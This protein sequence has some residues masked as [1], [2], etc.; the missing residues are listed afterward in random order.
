MDTRN[1]LLGN[2]S[3]SLINANWRAL[4]NKLQLCGRNVVIVK[5][6]PFLRLV[7]AGSVYIGQN[8]ALA[9]G[10][11]NCATA[12][13]IAKL[14]FVDFGDT[15]LFTKDYQLACIFGDA[16][17]SSANDVVYKYT[18]MQDE[19][20]TISLSGSAFDTE[21]Y[22]FESMCPDEALPIACSDDDV[23]GQDGRTLNAHITG[24]ELS[25]GITYY[26]VIDGY[27]DAQ[28]RYIISMES[29]DC[30][31]CTDG[32]TQEGESNCGLGEN[33][34]PHDFVNGGCNSQ[35]PVFMSMTDGETICGSTA[36]NP[37]T[38]ARDTDWYQLVL[39]ER[40]IVTWLVNAEFRTQF[41]IV[42]NS[43]VADCEAVSC[44]LKFT[45]SAACQASHVSAMLDQG[46]W[47]FFVAPF[48]QDEG[49]CESDYTATI[50]TI[51]P[52]DLNGDGTVNTSD[53]LILLGS[54]GPCPDQPN[55]CAPDLDGD[56]EVDVNDLAILLNSWD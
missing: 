42:D 53:L 19:T 29:S 17:N 56:G 7:L 36:S 44:F 10:G 55:L 13:N 35:V 8:A 5:C 11:E 37:F 48:F 23:F 12:V 15:T 32:A 24:L 4:V 34:L 3:L 28:G 26:I 27:I 39:T 51:L 21:L 25:A 2:L 47:W 1:I 54:W 16:E 40:R 31:A 14:P 41:G 50:I 30:G 6:L 52:A 38:G 18:P 45:E 46:T 33:G 20:V 43:G 9:G 49:A 22:V